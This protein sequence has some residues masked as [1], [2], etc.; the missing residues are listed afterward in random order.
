MIPW[1]SVIKSRLISRYFPQILEALSQMVAKEQ[2]SGILD[3]ILGSLGRLILTNSSLVPLKAVLPVFVQYLP[4]REDFEENEVVFKALD[5]VYRQGSEELLPLLERCL[6]VALQVLHLKQYS[7]DEV[8]DQIFG[9][10]KQARADF[11]EKFNN[12]VNSNPEIANFVQS[13]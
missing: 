7:K 2:H 6:Q 11:P 8:R 12:L 13:L 5:V 4:L 10:V 3:N 1:D 9:F